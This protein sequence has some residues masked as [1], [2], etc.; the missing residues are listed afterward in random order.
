[1]SFLIAETGLVIL[2]I[3]VFAGLSF[4]GH[5][6]GWAIYSVGGSPVESNLGGRLGCLYAWHFIDLIPGI[7]AWKT[8]GDPPPSESL[9]P[10]V[11]SH[12]VGRV[13]IIS[14]KI[15]VAFPTIALAAKWWR[16]IN[17]PAATPAFPRDFARS[18][19]GSSS[20]Q[21][22]PRETAG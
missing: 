15:A 1:M 16:S 7:D 4:P 13:P 18:S 10:G 11:F 9:P 2:G 5:Y 14:F 6:A 8:L 22:E 12:W 3:A 17:E 19:A 21:G 20:T